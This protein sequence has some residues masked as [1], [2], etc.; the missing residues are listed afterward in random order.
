MAKPK[1][2]SSE[3]C[4]YQ[5]VS[6]DFFGYQKWFKEEISYNQAI[7]DLDMLV[8]LSKSAYA[9]YDDA[10]KRGLEIEQIIEKFR[11]YL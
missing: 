1:I 8:Y 6:C 11:K 9:G 3:P 5:D 4:K 10:V 7:E 2:I